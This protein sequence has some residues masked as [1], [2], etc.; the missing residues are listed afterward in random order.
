MGAKQQCHR[1]PPCSL[2]GLPKALLGL[3]ERPMEPT[4]ALG[5]RE[6]P[7]A[8]Q[9]TLGAGPWSPGPLGLTALSLGPNQAGRLCT[10]RVELPRPLPQPPGARGTADSAAHRIC[11]T[12]VSSAPRSRS[13]G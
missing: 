7:C 9:L 1:V 13:V 10:D 11:A 4:E 6:P 3:I 12:R 8:I 5:A 2:E